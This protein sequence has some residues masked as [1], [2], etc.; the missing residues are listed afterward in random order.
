MN[1]KSL[2]PYKR[3]FEYFIDTL[4]LAGMEF[5]I[6]QSSDP[7]IKAL[8]NSI[9]HV[10]H[11]TDHLRIRPIYHKLGILGT[12][13]LYDVI[14]GDYIRWLLSQVQGIDLQAKEPEHWRV[15]NL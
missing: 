10:D 2:N 13:S 9:I 5:D 15:N 12:Y 1:I 7:L 14:Y 11:T 6:Q 4:P 8:Y 3:V